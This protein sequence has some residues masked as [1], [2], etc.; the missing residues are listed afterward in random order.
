VFVDPV[1]LDEAALAALPRPSAVVLTARCHQRSAWRYRAQFA[2]EVWLPADA[3]PADEEPD[4]RYAEG[5]VLPGGLLVVRTP[6]PEWPHYSFV[7]RD[8]PA[9]LFCSDLISHEGGGKLSF[10]PFEYHEDPAATRSSVEKLLEL[11]FSILCFDHGEPLVDEPKGKCCGGCSQETARRAEQERPAAGPA[12]LDS[13]VSRPDAH[14]PPLIGG[15]RV[16]RV[17]V[18]QLVGEVGVAAADEAQGC[19]IGADVEVGEVAVVQRRAV[20]EVLR[21]S[22]EAAVTQGGVELHRDPHGSSGGF[23]VRVGAGAARATSRTWPLGSRSAR[24]RRGA[25]GRR[26]AR[27]PSSARRAFPPGSAP[28]ALVRNSTSLV[29]LHERPFV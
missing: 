2:L 5:D 19:P 18:V 17:A 8:E 1:R 12:V 13:D 27:L 28:A 21:L 6:G 22:L 7:R 26:S 15:N 4:R 23:A 9:V 16:N 24:G 3:S 25:R 14:P 11:P 10:I 29:A 20:W